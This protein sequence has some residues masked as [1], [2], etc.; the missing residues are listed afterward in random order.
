MQE[1]A[2]HDHEAINALLQIYFDGLH[3]CDSRKLREVL[4][5]QALYATASDGGLLTLQM[6]AYWR[7]IDARP[8][9]ASQ[10][11]ERREGFRSIEFIGGDTAVA[12]V[13]CT[14]PQKQYEDVLSL[15]KL[16]GR[17]WIIAKIFH[18]DLRSG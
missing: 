4:H 16:E 15:L 5:P 7:V 17:W 6:E 14:A 12:R 9:P 11:H 8:S 10:G 3:H 13:H 18:Y 2:Q 1:T